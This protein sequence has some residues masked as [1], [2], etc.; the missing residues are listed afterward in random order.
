MVV[1]APYTN[2]PDDVKKLAEDTEAAITAGKL[3]P[4][5]CPVIGQDGKEGRMQGRRPSRRRPDPRHELLRQGHRRQDPRK[6]I[7][8]LQHQHASRPGRR[9]PAVIVWRLGNDGGRVAVWRISDRATLAF[10]LIPAQEPVKKWCC[11]AFH[12]SLAGKM[13]LQ[14]GWQWQRARRVWCVLIGSSCTGT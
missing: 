2:M 12:D 3:H 13:I 14:G 8:R 6:I 7:R 11:Q 5:K 9:G 10:P 4:F 1:M